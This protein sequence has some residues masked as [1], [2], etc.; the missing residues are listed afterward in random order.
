MP[1]FIHAYWSHGSGQYGKK[2]LIL[3]PNV[4]CF[5]KS[6]KV[7]G[8]KDGEVFEKA[9]KVINRWYHPLSIYEIDGR[10]IASNSEQNALKEYWRVCSYE[11]IK[12]QF[13]VKLISSL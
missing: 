7:S 12:K 5:N 11:K 13:E 8:F 3:H 1:S 10:V 4:D 9:E 6:R 2:Y